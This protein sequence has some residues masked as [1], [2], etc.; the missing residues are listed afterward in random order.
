MFRR[1]MKRAARP[2]ASRRRGS[3]FVEYLL[4]LTIVG[5]GVIVGL[6]EVRD[7]LVEE[8]LELAAAISALTP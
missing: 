2:S 6:T 1:T 7:A 3:V 4:L 8:M 5:I